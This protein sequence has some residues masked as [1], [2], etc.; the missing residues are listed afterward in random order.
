MKEEV[1]F[2]SKDFYT[3]TIDDD[4]DDDDDKDSILV[5]VVN[6]TT[7]F[8]EKDYATELQ[9]SVQT[10]TPH[11]LQGGMQSVYSKPNQQ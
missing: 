9:S 10:K 5:K 8:L 1:I 4:D 11:F 3:T 7:N 2:I 6:S